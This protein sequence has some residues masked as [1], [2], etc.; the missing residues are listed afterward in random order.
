MDYNE[1][2]PK[3]VFQY[4]KEVSN[5]PHGS[6]NTEEI[7]KYLMD[8]AKEHNLKAI[9]DSGR[10][11]IIFKDGTKGFEH[12][13]PIILQG[14]MDMVCEKNKDTE[15]DFVPTVNIYGLTVQRLAVTTEL[16]LLIYLQFLL[17]TIYLIRLLRQL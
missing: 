15:H 7:S 9:Y 16:R 14:H 4:F 10:N 17:Q 12:S 13:E 3:I 5:I 11:I 1:L 6:G 2:E 8:F